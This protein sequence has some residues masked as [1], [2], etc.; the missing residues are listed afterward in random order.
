V[1]FGT[2]K[3][4]DSVFALKNETFG[5]WPGM[6]PG[7]GGGLVAGSVSVLLSRR[8]WA[9]RSNASFS[10]FMCWGSFSNG[11]DDTLSASA[12]ISRVCLSPPRGKIAARQRSERAIFLPRGERIKR[13][14]RFGRRGAGVFG[15][16]IFVSHEA[17]C[18]Q[19]KCFIPIVQSTQR[20]RVMFVV[21]KDRDVAYDS[22]VINGVCKFGRS[23]ML[24]MSLSRFH[25]LGD[26]GSYTSCTIC[27]SISYYFKI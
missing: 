14:A 13:T 23:S 11:R 18:R 2:P 4:L 8:F 20:M 3:L 1:A 17:P 6:A 22:R 26:F 21:H 15:G 27:I 12:H 9:E 5:G 25:L 10:G 24:W 16:D 7:H 19:R